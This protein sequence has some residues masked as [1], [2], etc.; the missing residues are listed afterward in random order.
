VCSSI[1]G[2]RLQD[3]VSGDSDIKGATRFV[4]QLA[5]DI[6]TPLGHMVTA[7]DLIQ[8]DAGAI[9]LFSFFHLVMLFA[10][11]WCWATVGTLMLYLPQSNYRVI[12]DG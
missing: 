8:V 1:V 9:P 10:V 7:L 4:R 3:V 6:R 2:G 11:I 12:F 5:H